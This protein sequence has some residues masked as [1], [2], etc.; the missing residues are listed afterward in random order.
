MIWRLANL[1][2]FK[3][4]TSPTPLERAERLGRELGA[5]LYIKRDDVMELALGGN[6]VR[7]LEYLVGDALSKGCDTLV[8]T[9]AYHSNHARL[10]AAAARKAGMKAYL[11]LTPP[12]EYRVQGNALL[13]A[14]LGAEVRLY[15][16]REGVEEAL[17]ELGEELKKQGRKPYIIPAGGASP[18]GVMGY[19]EAAHEILMQMKELGVK[20]KYVVHA[21]GTGATQAGLILGFKMLGADDIQVVGISVGKGSKAATEKVADLVNKAAEILR[22]DVRVRPEDITVIDKYVGGGYGVVNKETVEAIRKAAQ[23][24]A[25]LFD[26]VYT[27]K[28]IWGFM[29]MAERGE[30]GK[31]SDVVFIHTGGEPILFQRSEE[32]TQYL[33]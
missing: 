12:G 33:L 1:P 15:K 31:G 24:E 11:L 10:T 20:P 19:A 22:V 21:A 8:T 30:F 9:G 28:G 17:E 5:N 16:H 6:K 2:K 14:L 4:F 26:P 23:Y 27:G 29:D 18:I 25:L 7:K 32:L 13:D 3:L